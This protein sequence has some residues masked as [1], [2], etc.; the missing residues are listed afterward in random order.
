MATRITGPALF[1]ALAMTPL[2]GCVERTEEIAIEPDGSVRMTLRFETDSFDELYLGDAIPTMEGGW[3]VTESVEEDEEG[4]ETYT[5]NAEAI[6]GP[7]Q[8]LP[9]HFAP[10]RDPDVDT[11]LQF[12]TDVIIEQR[13]D[14]TYYHFH[15]VYPGR[16][17]AFHQA[18][19]DSFQ[20]EMD[21]FE[22]KDFEDMTRQERM[23]I[24]WLLARLETA[25]YE[26]LAR[27]AF[28]D[29]MPDGPQDAW[30][31]ARSALLKVYENLDPGRIVDLLSGEDKEM[32][33][34]AVE[35]EAAAFEERAIEAMQAA[36]REHDG[37]DAGHINA[38]VRRF[39]WHKRYY[40]ITEDLADD[41]FNIAVTMPGAIVGHNGDRIEDGAVVWEFTGE[42]LRDREIELLVTS[43]LP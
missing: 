31:N 34:K 9:S 40:E 14:G 28:K 5:L 24:V 23:Q 29:E 17:W 3:A 13:G 12:P 26:A 7:E 8:D 22:G 35:E 18:A 41:A 37:V 32:K 21:K 19:R 43:R 2:T 39:R 10:P 42:M 20:E 6:F 15:R 11:Y 4:K 1:I 38:F 36:L 16:A 27:W 33:E 30:L 25:K